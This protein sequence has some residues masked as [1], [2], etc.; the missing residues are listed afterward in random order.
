MIW[1]PHVTVAAVI[2]DHGRFLLVEEHVAGQRVY[3][4]PAGHLEQG[5]SLVDAV[6]RETLEETAWHFRPVALI[7]L[8]RWHHPETDTTYLRVAFSGHGLG[9]EDGRPLDA[10]IE[11]TLWMSAN[12]IREQAGKLRSPLV[13]KSID[14]YLAG[15]AYSLD[16]L[17]DVE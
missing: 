4:Q 9:F 10:G 2:E 7:G 3:N 16:L 17:A 5:E 13:L 8:Y 6:V 14:D 12:E 11:R 15:A 1:R